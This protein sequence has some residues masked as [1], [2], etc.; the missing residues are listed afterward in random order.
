MIDVLGFQ[1]SSIFVNYMTLYMYMYTLKSLH[2]CIPDH[3]L[4]ALHLQF[5]LGRAL[6]GVW[7]PTG[8]QENCMTW[9]H[10]Y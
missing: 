4:T 3:L 2:I 9:K 7:G 6:L 1:I 10:H 5:L 8:F